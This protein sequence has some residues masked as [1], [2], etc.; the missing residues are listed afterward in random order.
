MKKNTH[1]NSKTILKKI[2]NIEIDTLPIISITLFIKIPETTR[3]SP[4]TTLNP[5]T[6]SQRS[7]K[8]NARIY[9]ELTTRGS[10]GTTSDAMRTN[11][12]AFLCILE[13]KKSLFRAFIGYVA[14][15]LGDTSKF[16]IL[17][18]WSAI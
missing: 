10:Y 7:N 5:N 2:I 17:L 12:I 4:V 6:F 14:I 9:I 18:F 1:P 8:A 13:C 3:S 11:I 15:C 16:L